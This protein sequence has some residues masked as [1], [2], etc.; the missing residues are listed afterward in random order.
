[1]KRVQEQLPG[2]RVHMDAAQ[3]S[4]LIVEQHREAERIVKRDKRS[5]Y[6]R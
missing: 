6:F 2:P 5:S 4:G 3:L 1:M